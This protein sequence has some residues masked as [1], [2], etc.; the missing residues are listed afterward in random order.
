M[1]A[2]NADNGGHTVKDE[3]VDM[4]PHVKATLAALT[5]AD[6][7]EAMQTIYEFRHEQD[8]AHAENAKEL[9]E[10][11]PEHLRGHP[12]ISNLIQAIAMGAIFHPEDAKRYREEWER[13]CRSEGSA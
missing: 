11:T 9:L 4:G 1:D 8:T 7:R 6:I 5:V 2:A 12:F 3:G 10:A 13:L